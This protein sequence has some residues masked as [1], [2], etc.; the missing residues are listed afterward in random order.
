MFETILGDHL[1]ALCAFTRSGGTEDNDI[2]HFVVFILLA[3][4]L[5][6]P[7]WEELVSGMPC[8]FMV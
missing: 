2:L 5:P 1:V 3:A 4:S 6:I 7:L 8:L